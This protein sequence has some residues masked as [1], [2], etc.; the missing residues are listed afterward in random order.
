MIPVVYNIDFLPSFAKFGLRIPM[1]NDRFFKIIDNLPSSAKH[2]Q[3]ETP[4][5]DDGEEIEF[6]PTRNDLLMVHTPEFVEG[7]FSDGLTGLMNRCFEYTNEMGEPRYGEGFPTEEQATLFRDHIFKK[8]FQVKYAF[9]VALREGLSVCIGGGMH[10][11]RRDFGHGFCLVNDVVLS[12]LKLMKEEKIKKVWTIDV[13][14]HMG[15]GI[16]DCTFRDDRFWSVDLHMAKG[17]PNDSENLRID[18]KA[19]VHVPIEVEENGQYL[20]KLEVALEETLNTAPDPDL[21]VLL[22]GADPYE[23]DELQSSQDLKISLSDML[24]RDQLIYQY[25]KIKKVPISIVLAGG[26]GEKSWEVTSQ[27]LNWLEK[28]H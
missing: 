26:Y 25:V 2:H 9:D 12:S 17:W 27:F 3:P 13:D 4:K 16:I 11:A 1:A 5:N 22:L 7:L 20:R 23:E 18:S 21:I 19:N 14:A 28:N 24:S 15:D 10:H 8:V 6:F